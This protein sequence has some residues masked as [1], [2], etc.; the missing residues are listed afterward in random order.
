MKALRPL[1]CGAKI[2]LAQVSAMNVAP[3]LG[4]SSIIDNKCAIIYAYT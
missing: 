1:F 4:A 3:A 2:E